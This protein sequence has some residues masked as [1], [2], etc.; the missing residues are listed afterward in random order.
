DDQRLAVLRLEVAVRVAVLGRLERGGL[1]AEE[2]LLELC[3][4]G[5]LLLLLVVLEAERQR[6]AHRLL[7]L[8]VQLLVQLPEVVGAGEEPRAREQEVPRDLHAVLG[9][10]HPRGAD[11]PER[12]QKLCAEG[13]EAV[14]VSTLEDHE[15]AGA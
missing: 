12:R 7:A 14:A 10:H 9:A 1:S 4:A 13:A 8:A 15:D 5:R 2:L 6:L 3:E 11:G